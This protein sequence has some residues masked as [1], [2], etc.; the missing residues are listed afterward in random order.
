MCEV[1]ESI[2]PFQPN[3]FQLVLLY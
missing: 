2:S 1:L 3:W